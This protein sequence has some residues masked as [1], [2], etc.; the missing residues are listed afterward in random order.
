MLWS[1]LGYM[2]RYWTIA[3]LWLILTLIVHM[4]RA[5]GPQRGTPILVVR[6]EPEAPPAT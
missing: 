1:T 3:G 2:E 6:A 4:A 5:L